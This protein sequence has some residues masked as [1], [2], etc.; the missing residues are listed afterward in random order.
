MEPGI[1]IAREDDP[2]YGPLLAM[3]LTGEAKLIG[4]RYD[5]DGKKE[6][7]ASVGMREPRRGEM[8]PNVEVTLGI[9]AEY[10]ALALKDYANWVEVWWR[11]AI[12]NGVDAGA[13]NISIVVEQQT[14]GTWLVSCQDDGRG[15]DEDVLVNKFMQLG[16][17]T[18]K[19][20]GTTGG[21][22]KAKEV[23][24][25]PWIAY[26]IHTRD[27]VLKGAGS[28]SDMQT[29]TYLQGTR[30][31]VMM[32]ADNTTT[33][34][35]AIAFIGQ[36]YIPGVRFTV[37]G[38]VVKAKLKRGPVI[39]EIEGIAEVCHEAKLKDRF[40]GK[41][42]VRVK[43][44]DVSLAMFSKYVDSD[45]PGQIT[46][47]IIGRSTEILTANRDGFRDWRL[48]SA[49]DKFV[50]ELA[51][52]VSSALKRKKGIIREKFEGERFK[53][54]APRREA[55]LVQTLGSMEP[56]GKKEKKGA[57]QLSDE[58]ITTIGSVL[59]E[60]IESAGPMPEEGLVFRS[61]AEMGEV[62]LHGMAVRGATHL[63]AIAKQLAWQ[64]A[65]YLMNDVEDWKV[66]KKFYPDSMTR[67]VRLLAALWAEMCRFVLM[68]LGSA[69]EFGVGFCFDESAAAKC[70]PEGRENWLL[71]NPIIKYDPRQDDEI[72]NISHDVTLRKGDV[73]VEDYLYAL[74]VHECTH[75]ADGISYHNEAF[76][77][78]LTFNIAHTANKD[79]QVRA[80]KRIVLAREKETTERLRAEK[81]PR[82]PRAKKSAGLPPLADAELEQDRVGRAKGIGKSYYAA[83][84]GTSNWNSNYDKDL[85]SLIRW[86]EENSDEI[87]EIRDDKGKPVWRSPNFDLPVRESAGA[88]QAFAPL[89]DSELERLRRRAVAT[90]YRPGTFV[91]FK[92]DM[93]STWDNATTAQRLID[94]TESYEKKEIRKAPSGDVVWRSK[95]FNLP[96]ASGG[97]GGWEVPEG[98]VINLGGTHDSVNQIWVFEN[99]MYVFRPR[100]GEVAFIPQ[101]ENLYE[102][103]VLRGI[104]PVDVQSANEFWSEQG[105]PV[106]IADMLSRK[107]YTSRLSGMERL[108]GALDVP[109]TTLG[110]VRE[111][112]ESGLEGR[113]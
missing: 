40:A 108:L 95:A 30:I 90:G 71:L 87:Y 18:K 36:C 74:A 48:S 15:M 109:L 46:V 24:I 64:P 66:P 81:P 92:E 49:I 63:E 53:A 62:I 6:I 105:D 51:A 70:A 34:A 67:Q 101:Q 32:P 55:A 80:L 54:D 10:F 20:G 42:I 88:Q 59:T 31:S 102:Y 22:G 8:V 104:S 76:S 37:N 7:A 72:L 94:D 82:E 43:N 17:T 111:F 47:E 19:A 75:M 35:A 9:G 79:K 41:M 98:A 14:D 97:G 113:V 25:L 83:F 86:C 99:G 45:L 4:E 2:D 68:Q 11:E 100:D 65:F 96:L 21:F 106:S 33:A 26:E 85:Q 52:D 91:A 3:T 5:V 77:S 56:Q 78:A 69:Q 84:R 93:S 13:H 29:A 23:L 107:G 1:Y 58:Q 110:A 44:E 38:E 39:R 16:G 61:T 12:Q 73:S 112:S 89:A 60:L 57:H 103:L 27:R 50:G 28:K